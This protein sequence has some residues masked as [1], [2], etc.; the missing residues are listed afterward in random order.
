[1]ATIPMSGWF[2]AEH[3]LHTAAAKVTLPIVK[4]QFQQQLAD[5]K[6]VAAIVSRHARDR[7][8]IIGQPSPIWSA[9]DLSGRRHSLKDY[10]GK[11]VVLDFWHRRCGW[12]MR[13]MPQVKQLSEHFLGRPV[14]VLGMN[15]DSDPKDAQF[16]VGKL[17]L[18]YP[19]VRAEALPAKYM[20]PGFP[21]LMIIDQKGVIRDMYVGYSPTL[22][23]DASKVVESL[24]EGKSEGKRTSE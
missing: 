17:K 5:H 10:R 22:G 4:E 12:C 9:S 19:I 16:V 7:V 13:T 3:A 1:M 11:V 2:R 18:P 14:V 8:D 24:L 6:T 23:K 20:I 21:T 15:T